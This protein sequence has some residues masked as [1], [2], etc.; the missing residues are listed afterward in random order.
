MS[1]LNKYHIALYNINFFLVIN[2]FVLYSTR[3]TCD[4]FKKN[5]VDR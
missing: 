2:I 5:D 3:I 1:V 4:V